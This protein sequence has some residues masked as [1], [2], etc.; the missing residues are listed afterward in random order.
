MP[1]GKISFI[2][3]S[4]ILYQGGT[5]RNIIVFLLIPVL[6]L[7]HSPCFGGDFPYRE[8]YPEVQT[9]DNDELKKGIEQQNII[10]VDVRSSVEY[11]AIHIQGAF[12]IP[13]TNARFSEQL[14]KVAEENPG[15]KIVVYCN[16][17]ICIKSYKA[18]EDALYAGMPDVNAFDAGIKAWAKANPDKT[19]Y[20]GTLLGDT[21]KLAAADKKFDQACLN[22]DVFKKKSEQE[23]AVVIDARDPMQR[24][25]SLPGMKQTLQVPLDKLVNN[26][27]KK[28]HMKDKDLLIFDQVGKQV[29]WLIS[30][31]DENG[32]TDYYFLEGGATA[33]LKVQEYR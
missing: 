6:F 10:V 15:K 8:Y 24:K 27:I 17:I 31:L 18:A 23:K 9:I 20:N 14:R 1:R 3:F 12:N 28:G 32:Y 25:Q 7:I 26:I 19:V 22:F 13:Y 11:E 29:N 33:V 16:G 21:Q 4:C 5:M 30:Y 2:L